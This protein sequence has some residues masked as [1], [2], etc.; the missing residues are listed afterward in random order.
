MACHRLHSRLFPGRPIAHHGPTGK[1]E[2]RSLAAGLAYALSAFHAAGLILRYGQ[3]PV[4]VAVD[5]DQA[6]GRRGEIAAQEQRVAVRELGQAGADQHP[7]AARLDDVTES[8]PGGWRLA[9]GGNAVMRSSLQS[10]PSGQDSADGWATS[11]G[12][13]PGSPRRP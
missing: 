6:G 7:Q 12:A 3:Q 9:A 10:K 11:Q 8:P 4:T 13:E 5:A 1:G 2:L